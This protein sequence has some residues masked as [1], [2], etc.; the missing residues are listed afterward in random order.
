MEVERL[1]RS[2]PKNGKHAAVIVTVSP[3]TNGVRRHQ[4]RWRN[5]DV[6]CCAGEGVN[7][8]GVILQVRDEPPVYDFDS[9]SDGGLVPKHSQCGRCGQ[10]SHA[11]VDITAI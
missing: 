4:V 11:E 3:R 5:H 7:G 6:R 1:T 8:T 9:S 10:I 2:A